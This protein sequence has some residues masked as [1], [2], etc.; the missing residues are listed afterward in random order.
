MLRA[1]PLELRSLLDA[2]P[3]DD[4]LRR[5][6]PPAYEGDEDGESE[7]RRLM[8]DELVAGRR[9][10]LRVLEDTVDGDRLRDEEAH[11][12]LGALNDLRLVL[13]TRLGVTEEL[14]ERDF[15]P[16]DPRAEE[17]AVYLYLSWLQEQFVEALAGDLG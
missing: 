3:G 12:W 7:Y 5:L 10:A 13:G 1:L 15:D 17:L 4:D 6:F 16:R 11:A 8:D 9:N 14:Y 2:D